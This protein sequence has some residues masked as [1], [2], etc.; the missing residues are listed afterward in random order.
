MLRDNL[1]R[2]GFRRQL[3]VISAAAIFGLALFSSLINSSE[4]SRRM[5]GYTVEQG[6]RIAENFARQSAL[7]L[8]TNSAENAKEGVA[9]T[10]AFPDVLHV[11]ITDA[12]HRL[13]VSQSDPDTKL[14][15][16]HL[17]P[18]ANKI[19]QTMLEQENDDEWLFSAPVFG[20]QTAETSPFEVQVTQAQLLGYVHVAISKSTLNRLANSLLLANL[21]ITLSFAAIL[22][23]LMRLLVGH[24]MR[25]LN[26]LS[27]LMGR[28]EAGESEMRA[29][30]EG[31][32]DIVNMAIAFNKMMAVLEE[33]ENELKQS[34][35]DAVQAALLKAQFAAMV[36]HEVRTP[37][38]GVVGMLDILK[39]MQ[40]TQKQQECVEIAWNSSHA[41]IALINDVLDFSKMEAGKM[42]LEEIEI[43]PR[44]L[45]EDVIE[46]L[47]KTAN[48]KGLELGYLIDANVPE[49]ILGD[50]LR[51]RQVLINL[52]GNAIK[53][54]ESGEVA[55]HITCKQH[56]ETQDSLELCF[57]VSDT[58]IGMT[59]AEAQNIFESFAQAA[60]STT[61]KFGGTGLGL[62]ICKQ[63]V[64]LMQGTISVSSNQGRGA[65]F[66]FSALC[67]LSDA[68]EFKID[69][70]VSPLMNL[71]VLAVD[72]SDIIRSFLQENLSRCGAQCMAVA[73]GAIALTELSNAKLNGQPYQLLI[74]DKEVNDEHGLSLLRHLQSDPGLSRPQLLILEHY[75]ALHFN[76]T[77]VAETTLY[78]PLRL[79][80]LLT[81]LKNLLSG[82]QTRAT[83]RLFS[84]KIAHVPDRLWRVLV[85]EDNRTNQVVAAGMLKINGCFCEF[86]GN[87]KEALLAARAHSFD[88]ILMDCNMPEMD[89]YEATAHIRN[90]EEPLGRRTPIIA[91][92]ANTQRGD[93]EKC[94]SAGMDDYLAK[95]IT[96]FELRQKLD[97]W[98]GRIPNVEYQELIQ[99]EVE[100]LAL[101]PAIFNKLRELLGPS[102]EQAVT[103]FLEDTPEYLKNLV[104]A[105][106]QGD[107]E[108]VRGMAHSIKGSSGNL[109]AA[110]L[111]RLA[112]EVESLA[113]E[114]RLDEIRPLVAGLHDAFDAVAESLEKENFAIDATDADHE[115]EMPLVLI[116]DDDR[117]TRS[118]LRSVLQLEGFRVDEA[119]NGE[120]A[121]SLLDRIH[122]DIILMDA[123]MPVM[124]GFTACARLQ[125]LPHSRDI[126][127]LMITALE[128]NQSVE[129]AFA[130]G[131]SDYIPKPIHFAVL[132]QRVRRVIDSS[133]SEKRIRHLAYSDV[134]TGLPNRVLFIDELLLS[135]EQARKAG[136]SVAVLFL[137]L[138]R[139]KNVNDTLGHEIGDKLLKAV[140]QR[141]RQS[142][143]NVD[144]VARLGGD[145]FTI[146]LNNV[147]GTSAA[148]AAQHICQTLSTPFDID[149]NDIFVT[150][151]VGI[152][153]Y[154]I[155]GKDVNT[156]LKHADTA[157]YRAKKTKNSFQF[158]EAAMEQSIS[159]HV[160]LENDLRR[161]L[162]R[163]EME[164]Y[165]QPQARLDNG[166]IVGMEALI[167]WNH[168]SRGLVSPIEFIPLAE[169]TGLINPLGDWVLRTACDQVQTW[170]KA[171]L[172]HIKVAVNISVHQL[173]QKNF[174][175]IV[176]KTLAASGLAPDLLELEIT[177][178]T[179]MEHAQDTLE[180]LHR[181]RDLGIR[182]SIDDFGTGY[183]SLAY[184][185]RFPVDIIKIDRSFVRDICEDADDAAIVTGII[186]LAHSL[187]LEVV[188]EGVE[189]EAQL[190]FLREKSCDLM[191]GFY[192]SKAVPA[193]QFLH[194]I[195]A[196]T[197]LLQ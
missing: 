115:S 156:L 41:L 103:P 182:L 61:R 113:L 45:I 125:E 12:S 176:E 68:H 183:S 195:T 126:P 34:R 87:G 32:K 79:D 184:L 7:A 162:E 83:S 192:L 138:D 141:L 109:G 76:D 161:A 107:S 186:A 119:K 116:V 51:L 66:S 35:D 196:K 49:H 163:N 33:R 52:I 121:L 127:V 136:E 120:Q 21:V 55:I 142:V 171:G 172:P 188:A 151:S 25:P 27:N 160:R 104:H 197:K 164:V 80:R 145:E 143:R 54:T 74:L 75:G 95:P 133:R 194:L 99:D 64:E 26:A 155:D 71:R 58:G 2:T 124:D 153:L 96:L 48:Q 84:P 102:L 150:T 158:F 15:S 175:A 181:L 159:E 78:K 101:D 97:R 187:R 189:T 67:K 19:K 6:L 130:A 177:E 11:Q 9:T 37:L 69:D 23:G 42:E 89:G 152:S 190:S 117:S 122:P 149:G 134:L 193:D 170:I 57:E 14:A 56:A 132:S 118:T 91:M 137:D 39:E 180:A 135:I 16:A 90:F 30:P 88:L 22:L 46:L 72:N 174:A 20:G 24:M 108:M 36:S 167:R 4:A 81:A 59:E 62:A 28:A 110:V 1:K 10:L 38:N 65:K 17:K 73:S 70:A 29:T 157:M 47:A 82:T 3:T 144:S 50:S 44:E 178:S 147:D 60:R 77:A 53:F 173:M 13:L 5:R 131:A 165:Y 85:A 94:L 148:V 98:L 154:P 191:Q 179:L 93:A 128:D 92:T 111:G 105:L 185:K 31:P 40:L 100:E 114:K 18:A 43:K 63:L 169:E 168:P 123:M 129:R 86:A 112:K 139:F 146:V 166:H 8:L 140:A 106:I